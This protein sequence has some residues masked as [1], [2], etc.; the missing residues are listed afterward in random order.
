MDAID[1]QQCSPENVVKCKSSPSSSCT[2]TLTLFQMEKAQKTTKKSALNEVVTREYTIHLHKLVFG[3]TFKKRAPKA[4]KAIKTFATR[5][6]GTSD[7][8]VDPSLNKHIW[9]NGV[10]SVPH[11]VRVRLSR[12]R[13]DSENAKEK[14]YTYVTVVPTV[15]FKGLLNQTVDE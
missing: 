1:E 10:K 14:L 12:K 9:A 2:T 15:N 5:A 4:I 11:R 13:N 7:V 6:M 8:R 3:A